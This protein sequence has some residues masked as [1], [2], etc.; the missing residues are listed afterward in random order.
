MRYP[1]INMKNPADFSLLDF[2]A[3]NNNR[4]TSGLDYLHAVYQL[5][6][7]PFDFLL[8]YAQLLY[9]TLRLVYG[10]IFID[11]QFNTDRYQELCQTTGSLKDA[12]YWMNLL[13]ITG[14]FGDLQ[15]EQATYLGEMIACSW[16]TKISAE[17]DSRC[18]YAQCIT[19][20][21]TGEVFLTIV[22]P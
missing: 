4:E 11:S 8:Q 3:A 18:T 17:L 14:I 5:Q 7:L 20:K 21:E 9:P 16:N 6:P 19:D 22:Q 15:T 2:Q 1:V 12:Q 13:E 10:R